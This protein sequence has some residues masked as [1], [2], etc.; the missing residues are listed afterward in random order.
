MKKSIFTL[1]IF[2]FSF[3]TFAQDIDVYK[4]DLNDH[5]KLPQLPDSMTFEEF[6][7]LSTN[8]RLID[9]AEA[10][11]VPGLIHFKVKDNITGFSL[12]GAR[13]LGYAGIIYVNL[14]NKELLND[15][16][17]YQVL[18]SEESKSDYYI[19]LGSIG[20][21]A[22]SYFYDWI[23]GRYLLDKKQQ[24]IRYK[25]AVKLRPEVVSYN[26]PDVKL[27]PELSLSITF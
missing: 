17:N 25:Y 15:V 3:N 26:A 24:K 10:L 9:A 1:F 13:L 22:G 27:I 23:H 19:A 8:V 4:R 21:I 12:V 7:V 16:F 6:K 14:N 18:N 5:F 11:I 2:A 20:L